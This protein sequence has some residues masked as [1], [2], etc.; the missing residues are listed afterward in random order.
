MVKKYSLYIAVLSSTIN[1]ALHRLFF[2]FFSMINILV[3]YHGPIC[4]LRALLCNSSPQRSLSQPYGNSPKCCFL[5]VIQ[6]LLQ[7]WFDD[8]TD[9]YRLHGRR[10]SAPRGSDQML[11][12][13]VSIEILFF[14][15]RTLSQLQTVEIGFALSYI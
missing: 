11:E 2:F 4:A 12:A 7:R 10:V 14:P 15:G 8:P 13:S 6:Q 3:L 1:I 9:V 5:S